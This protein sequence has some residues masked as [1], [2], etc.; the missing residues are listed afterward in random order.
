VHRI[1]SSRVR[2]S[3]R[4]T[5]ILIEAC[6]SFLQSLQANVGIVP[7]LGHKSFSPSPSHFIIHRHSTVR[8]RVTY[9]SMKQSLSWEAIS[10]SASQEIPIFYET[11]RFITVFTESRQQYLSW[12][13]WIQSNF[14]IKI[15]FNAIV[16]SN[17][18]SSKWS[19]PSGFATKILC[20]WKRILK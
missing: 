17:P 8:H 3:A 10:H 6:H 14:P 4:R 7:F 5:V 2:I 12:T 19:P 20:I 15:H 18:I 16:L 11:R 13:R 9:N 1:R